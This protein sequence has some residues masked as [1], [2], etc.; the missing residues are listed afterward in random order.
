MSAK[1]IF[2]FAL[3]VLAP[4]LGIAAMYFLS[5]QNILLL[6]LIALIE[7]LTF[8]LTF[9]CVYKS[10]KNRW[11]AYSLAKAVMIVKLIHIPAYVMNFVFACLC[12]MMLF[13]IPWA[14]IYFVTDCIALVM[15]GLVVT[16]AT[17]RAMNE[18]PKAFNKYVWII[19]LQFVF[20]ADVFAAVFLYKK[21]KA[22][23]E[24][25]PQNPD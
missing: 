1:R 5:E 18:N 24:N 16:S 13:T 4:Y 14:L 15:S 12:F 21:L 8:T 3:L 7:C 22:E 19:P 6:V 17:L 2:Y 23:K 9:G 20:C 10:Q 11:D 25:V